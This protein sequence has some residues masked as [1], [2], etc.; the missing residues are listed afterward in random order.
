MKAF[1]LP[2]ADAKSGPLTIEPRNLCLYGTYGIGKTPIALTLP[3]AH[4]G[5]LDLQQGT[6]TYASHTADIV[7]L[8]EKHDGKPWEVFLECCRQ[9]RA[10]NLTFWV[11]D[12]IGELADWADPMALERFKESPVGKSWKY[13]DESGAVV[14]TGFNEPSILDLP[15]PSGS[16][17][18][19]KM[20]CAFD[21]LFSACEG[22]WHKTVFIGHPRD[23]IAFATAPNDPNLKTDTK[24]TPDDLDLMGKMRRK[25]SSQMAATG[26]MVRNWEGNKIDVHFTSKDAFGKTRCAHLDGRVLQFSNPCRL[27]EWARIYPVTLGQYLDAKDREELTPIVERLGFKIPPPRAAATPAPT[28]DGGAK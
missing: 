9:Y 6:E 18:F 12:T 3:R 8:A 7:K 26:F 22:S 2:A 14:D 13:K 23:K 5:Y 28:A 11:V 21:E 19:G 15:G 17:G 10:R 4:T 24:V 16:P 27:A 1:T 20:W 25:F